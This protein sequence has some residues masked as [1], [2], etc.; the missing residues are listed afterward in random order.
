[1]TDTEISFIS[2]V[3]LFTRHA[4]RGKFNKVA[5][6]SIMETLN[7]SAPQAAS[8]L[9]DHYNE[10]EIN[11]IFDMIT[12]VGDLS[13]KCKKLTEPDVEFLNKFVSII[14]KVMTEFRL[15]RLAAW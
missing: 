5:A 15:L 2:H 4:K 12:C 6:E 10:D 1:M 9:V 11:M 14:S 8:L 7:E 3:I 13:R